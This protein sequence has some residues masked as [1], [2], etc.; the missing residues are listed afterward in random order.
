MKFSVG[1]GQRRSKTFL[2]EVIT[3]A[4]NIGEVY[5][6]YG[7][8]PN[9]RNSQLMVEGLTPEEAAEQQHR[10]LALLSDAGISLNVLFN[11]MCYGKDSQS[12]AFFE[13]V[14][15]TVDNLLSNY[16]LTAVTTTSLLI[17]KFIKENFPTLDVRASVNMGIGT[18][19]G[20]EYVKDYFDSFY[21]ARE[22]NRDFN[23]LGI[24]KDWCDKHGKRLYGLANSGCLNFCSAHTFHDNLVAHEAEIAKMDNGYDFRGICKDYL[25]N[26]NNHFALFD[27]TSFIRPEDVHYF[28]E[29]FSGMKLAT[30][31]HRNPE[32]VLRAYLACKSLGSALSLLEPDHT[33]VIYPYIL[34]NAK[35]E[36]RIENGK[37][38]YDNLSNALIR[39]ED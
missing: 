13:G 8:Y 36:S 23:R 24:L 5:F 1:L 11:A 28:E 2:D 15:D 22:Y 21:A 7:G 27:N 4:D 16:N 30:R 34:E 37:L 26:P 6:S 20:L 14:G 38:I 25:S 9:G 35:I 3:A 31:V 12:R 18:I 39:L 32:R 17:A 10:D 33:G 29:F 19:E